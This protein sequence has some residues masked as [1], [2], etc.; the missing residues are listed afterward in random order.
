[1]QLKILLVKKYITLNNDKQFFEF[2]KYH[3]IKVNA[4]FQLQLIPTN[5]WNINSTELPHSLIDIRISDKILLECQRKEKLL[6]DGPSL[7]L[8]AANLPWPYVQFNHTC[9]HDILI[10]RI[11]L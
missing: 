9:I 11:K 8:A 6:M 3:R 10:L 7:S 2:S 1:M 5:N 4:F